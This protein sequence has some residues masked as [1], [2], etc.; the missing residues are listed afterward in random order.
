M[1]GINYKGL[2]KRVSYGDLANVLET[3]KAKIKYPD[4]RATVFL[5]DPRV[6]AV[7]SATDIEMNEQQENI[8]KKYD[9][10]EYD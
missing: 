3:D 6:L 9:F 8:T 4:R 1:Y 2:K 10:S 7:T 5:N